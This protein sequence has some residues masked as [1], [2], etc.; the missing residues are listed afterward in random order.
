MQISDNGIRSKLAGRN[1]ST[2][3][4]IISAANIKLPNSIRVQLFVG[5]KDRML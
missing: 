3:N 5:W 2:P 1:V 4:E